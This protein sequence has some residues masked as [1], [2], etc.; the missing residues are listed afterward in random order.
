LRT[1][2][3]I[4]MNVFR[5]GDKV[6]F[7]NEVGSG[8][9]S[10]II[11]DEMVMIKNQDDWEMPVMIGELIPDVE[12]SY[13]KEDKENRRS[14]T[15]R[16]QPE[17]IFPPEEDDEPDMDEEEAEEEHVFEEPEIT[18]VK[19]LSSNL[20]FALV[21]DESGN[22]ATSNLDAY[23]INESGYQI[24]YNYM[25][26][27]KGR[28]L[29]RETG[30][31]DPETKMFLETYKRDDLNEFAAVCIQVIY[32][33][34]G[35]YFPQEPVNRQ[36]KLNM[37]RFY[38]ETSFV[39]NDYFD[40]NAII[41][42]INNQEAE[43]IDRKK[44]ELL[45]SFVEKPEVKRPVPKKTAP[46]PEQYEINLHINELV[47]TVGGLTNS[48]ILKIQMDQV[49]ASIKEAIENKVKKVVFIHGV[50]NGILKD[51][52]RKLVGKQYH[53][54]CQDASFR[55][56]GYGATIVFIRQNYRH[57]KQYHKR[58]RK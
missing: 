30:T 12:A 14:Y 9:V 26:K 57:G 6:K 10:K 38:K 20:T 45:K 40:D 18:E 56:Y 21:P 16:F 11:N 53:F 35:A 4:E 47:E 7:L 41:Y 37:T 22:L 48:Q 2:K 17:N 25:I 27:Y 52:I 13:S 28:W 3:H 58:K 31:L 50:G 44:E 49:H 42:Q 8:V 24:F 1:L 36:I 34:D 33:Q 55:E 15:E 23:L 51:E 43:V 39:K 54:D 46:K 32:H 29:G 19:D 5:I